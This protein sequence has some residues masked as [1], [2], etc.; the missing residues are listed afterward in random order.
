[1]TFN[2]WEAELSDI[3]TAGSEDAVKLKLRT[4]CSETK[5]L[6][7]RPEEFEAVEALLV[8]LYAQREQEEP[9]CA[10][11]VTLGELQGSFE[12]GTDQTCVNCGGTVTRW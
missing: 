10:H 4:S 8:E 9:V 12:S 5:W 7:L 3:K 1:M 2:Y 6:T 11:N